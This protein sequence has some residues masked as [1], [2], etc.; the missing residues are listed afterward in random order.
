MATLQRAA[1][2]LQNRFLQTMTPIRSNWTL[3]TATAYGVFV[4]VGGADFYVCGGR[5][6]GSGCFWV[7][8][9]R[10]LEPEV[11]ALALEEAVQHCSVH[12]RRRPKKTP[13]RIDSFFF[14]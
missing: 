6:F 5:T 10:V 8:L 2:Q 4:F 1:R 14:F 7:G 11:L 3:R 9:Q 13:Q 12:Q